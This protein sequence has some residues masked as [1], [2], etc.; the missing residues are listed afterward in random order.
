MNIIEP[1]LSWNGALILNNVPK[2]IVDHHAEAFSCSIQDIDRWHK[3]R[4]WIGCG[5]HFLVRKDGSVYRGR[6]ENAEGA[7]CYGYN[8][9]SLGVCFEGN[10]ME[11]S[12]PEVQKQAGIELHKYLIGKYQ[13]DRIEPHRALY[14]TSCPG[15]KFPFDGIKN[16]SL[17]SQG[18]TV[19]YQP[20]QN[21]SWLQVGDSGDKVKQLQSE[22]IKLGYDLGQYG[23]DGEYGQATK[24]AVYKFQQDNGLSS[25]GLAGEQTFNC[26]NSKAAGLE[27]PKENDVVKNFQ[28]A[29]N[30]A[31]Y[32][33]LSEDG[34]EGTATDAVISKALLQ[35][36]SRGE[37]VKWL[38][39]RLMALGFSCGSSGADGV[40]G[41]CTFVAV[42]NFQTSKGL[43]KDGI[44]GPDTIKTLLK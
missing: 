16:A 24:N 8:T 37:L 19:N 41:N 17:N 33:H 26:L 6:P 3:E 27:A 20:I 29:S 38:Q 7:H 30:L 14:N 21:R 28:Q 44:A 4:G 39:N 18:S 42:Q 25:D 1:N 32:N 13:L 5:Y 12:M 2:L 40:F 15:D 10:Y 9:N 36:G 35:R 31:G 43:A 11:D 23:A 22:L 34:I